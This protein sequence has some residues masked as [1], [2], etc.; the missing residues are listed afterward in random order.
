MVGHRASRGA[1][2]PARW[3]Q[4]GCTE[5]APPSLLRRLWWLQ[6]LAAEAREQSPE[7]DSSNGAAEK[8]GPGPLDNGADVYVVS[9]QDQP[10]WS[11]S[12]ACAYQTRGLR[13]TP[14]PALRAQ[15]LKS[16]GVQEQLWSFLD[17][18]RLRQC[19]L[20]SETTSTGRVAEPASPIRYC[21]ETLWLPLQACW[22]RL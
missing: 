17:P 13:G 7:P 6:D 19:I 21:Q 18:L 5:Q 1:E 14:A 20:P 16:V 22:R 11:R 9:N 12:M 8:Q 2:L 4:V 3:Q 10:G 15:V